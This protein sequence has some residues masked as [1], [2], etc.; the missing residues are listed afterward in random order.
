MRWRKLKDRGSFLRVQVFFAISSLR[1]S[2]PL[3]G[4]AV[5]LVEDTS[6]GRREQ[7][8]Q[9]VSG[10]A[11]L[12]LALSP[13]VSS[14]INGEVESSFLLL[15]MQSEFIIYNQWSTAD[16]FLSRGCK[17]LLFLKLY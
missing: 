4:R 12:V 17:E 2:R 6:L 16:E 3:E 14:E 9:E 10:Q 13:P 5:T 15:T 7:H 8:R 11:F 1:C